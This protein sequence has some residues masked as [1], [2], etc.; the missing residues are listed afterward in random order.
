MLLI[1]AYRDVFK[2]ERD[3]EDEVLRVLVKLYDIVH[4]PH[5]QVEFYNY[6]DDSDLG[7]VGVDISYRLGETPYL[8]FATGISQSKPDDELVLDLALIWEGEFN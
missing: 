5:L 1:D 7:G 8:V 4:N 2:F 3:Y 6:L